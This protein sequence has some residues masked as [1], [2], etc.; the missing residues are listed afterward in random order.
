MS[1]L[2]LLAICYSHSIPV[3]AAAENYSAQPSPYQLAQATNRPE[4]RVPQASLYTVEG[5]ALGTRLVMGSTAYREYKC[6]PSTQ[7][8]GFT[9][10][11][12]ERPGS[13]PRGNFD[14][15]FYFARC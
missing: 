9:W 4:A 15:I 11:T 1:R 2:L 6:Q 8:T 12:K 3:A 5:L 13:E 7:F 14:I 10:C